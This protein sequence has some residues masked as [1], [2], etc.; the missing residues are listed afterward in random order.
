MT[1]STLSEMQSKLNSVLY[2][3]IN[4]SCIVNINHV[5]KV[6]TDKL[7]IGSEAFT[8]NKAQRD[9]ILQRLDKN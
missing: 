3:K 7:F 4:R 5:T 1:R 2:I 9:V 8:V 6:E